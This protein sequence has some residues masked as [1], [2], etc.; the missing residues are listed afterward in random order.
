ME[1]ILLRALKA[2]GVVIEQPFVPE[3][4]KIIEEGGLAGSH[5]EVSVS[6]ARSILEV[7]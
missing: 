3:S 2:R 7:L 1:G 6:G 4:L 5:V